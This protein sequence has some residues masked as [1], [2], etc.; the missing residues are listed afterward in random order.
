MIRYE[1]DLIDGHF[2][3][4]ELS[5]LKTFTEAKHPFADLHTRTANLL[6][7]AQT[8]LAVKQSR[9]EARDRLHEFL[10][11]RDHALFQDTQ[12]TGLDPS[13]N[14]T[15]VRNSTLKALELFAADGQPANLWTPGAFLN[16]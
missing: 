11:R 14:V 3:I 6:A 7:K 4:E 2:P 1:N 8:G 12:L 5:R 15:V 16:H 10:R 13:E 9:E